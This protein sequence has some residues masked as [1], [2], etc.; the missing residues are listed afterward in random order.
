[1]CQECGCTITQKS[2]IKLEN[3]YSNPQLN[4]KKTIDIIKKILDISR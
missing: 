3:I 1:M 2:D 4:S